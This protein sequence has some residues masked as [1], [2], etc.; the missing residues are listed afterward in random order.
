MVS[1]SSSNFSQ[2]VLRSAKNNTENFE[3]PKVS[4]IIPTLNSERTLEK[5]LKSI[6][7]QK[8][9]SIEIIKSTV[10]QLTILLVLQKDMLRKSLSSEEV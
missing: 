5:C 2:I 4:F 3:L 8:Y 10:A 6:I 9:P 1:S 7:A